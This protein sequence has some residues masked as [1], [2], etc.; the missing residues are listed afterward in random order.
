[1]RSHVD[2]VRDW[3]SSTDWRRY[4]VAVVLGLGPDR[5][6]VDAVREHSDVP[7]IAYDPT[8]TPGGDDQLAPGVS[9]YSD[10]RVMYWAVHE[11]GKSAT[12]AAVLIS[13]WSVDEYG[14]PAA[15]ALADAMHDI[16]ES[17]HAVDTTERSFGEQWFHCL[18]ATLPRIVGA[19]HVGRLAG[20]L[21]GVPAGIIGAGPS[22]AK[23]VE[24]LRSLQGRA[25]L[26]ACTPALKQLEDA[27]VSVD[28]VIATDRSDYII[29]DLD[30]R[31]GLKDK[32][33]VSGVHPHPGVWDVAWRRVL[34]APHE[35]A[36]V[37][38]MLERHFGL[39]C[40]MTGGSVSTLAFSV[41]FVLGCDPL[42][43]VGQDFALAEGGDYYADGG[44]RQHNYTD[45][46]DIVERKAWSGEG[47][48]RSRKA[49]DGYA[50]YLEDVVMRMRQ[51]GAER[52][53][54]NA[55]EGGSYVE[56]WEHRELASLPLAE[57]V[58]IE[59]RLAATNAE[60]I[61]HELVQGILDEQSHAAEAVAEA[62]ANAIEHIDKWTVEEERLAHL[63]ET[64][65]LVGCYM[66]PAVR[67]AQHD[68]ETQQDP[69]ARARN[70]Y[71]AI[72]SAAAH[73]K[74]EL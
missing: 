67:A 66:R 39:P 47:T 63:I 53:F 71:S 52:T 65:A 20:A 30:C 38:S 18:L 36:G 48:V 58:D 19:H 12:D 41:A 60:P 55:T 42:I 11:F 62:V 31:R 3:A 27:D 22:L 33:F 26:I 54:I 35:A 72:A 68:R 4:G 29:R 24:T 73:V 56:G 6:T 37:G 57:P 32:I 74:K 14:T 50:S 46:H 10:L 44:A 49:L 5:V 7:I 17:L 34:Y 70:V 51:A 15:D 64:A 40:I 2:E 28:A 1:M 45:S 9:L 23:N 16:Y 43:L 21:H 25:F 13:E 61:T 59:A 69:R 8:H